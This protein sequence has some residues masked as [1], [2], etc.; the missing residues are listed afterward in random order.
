MIDSPTY[1]NNHKNEENEEPKSRDTVQKLC[2]FFTLKDASLVLAQHFITLKL[3]H[4][5]GWTQV[6]GGRS[7]R[8]YCSNTREVVC[9]RNSFIVDSVILLN[10]Y[11]IDDNLNQAACCSKYKTENFL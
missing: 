9:E 3:G 1:T 5:T 2:T 8:F 4:K 10:I 7:N 11:D 6:V